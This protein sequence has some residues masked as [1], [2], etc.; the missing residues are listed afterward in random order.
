VGEKALTEKESSKIAELLSSAIK[1]KQHPHPSDFQRAAVVLYTAR[2][3]GYTLTETDV[4]DIIE[5]SEDTYSETIIGTLSNMA[6]AYND[7]VYGMNNPE[8]ESYKF[9]E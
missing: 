2:E 9:K 6:N 8:N 5:Q 3:R 1:N 7:L 4:Y